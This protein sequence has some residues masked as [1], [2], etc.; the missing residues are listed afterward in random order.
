[1][2]NREF[3]TAESHDADSRGV[4]VCFNSNQRKRL[5]ELLN[6]VAALMLASCLMA[7]TAWSIDKFFPTFGNNGIDV[8]HYDLDLDVSIV[9]HHLE[10]AAN[11]DV[12]A[13]TELDSFSLD[14]TGLTVSKVTVRGMPADFVQED[15]KLKIRPWMPIAEG[16]VFE[17]EILYSGTPE[18]IQDPTF[19]NDPNMLLGWFKYED[20]IYAVSE[21]VGAS[22]FYPAN[23]EP[24]DKATFRIAVTV[25]SLATAVSNGVLKST[26]QVGEKRRF[27]WEMRQPMTSWLVTVHVNRFDVR[28]DRTPKGTPLRFYTTKETPA[29]DLEGYA[30]TGEMLVYFETLIGRY[31]FDGYGSVVVDDPAL[32]YAL[33]TQAMSTF[34]SYKADEGRVAHELAHQWF[35]NSVSVAKW[36]DLWLAEGPATYFEVLWVHR[37]DPAAFA[38]AMND[39][40][41]YVVQEKLGPAVVEAPELI[42]SDRTYLRGCIA[43]YALQLTV[44]DKTFFKILRRFVS[45]YRGGN[46]TSKNFINTA[47]AVSRH[48]SV[49]DLLE[50]WLYEETVPPLPGRAE[51]HSAKRG[52]VAAPDVVGLR[53]GRGAHRGPRAS[54]DE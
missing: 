37:N 30:L 9:P 42:F 16:D 38:L 50:A 4:G 35:G 5:M 18:P 2:D 53:C 41:D 32:Y 8:L 44:G 27:V 6:K 21:P 54:C 45:K 12:L 14:L 26:T 1:M 22:T 39:M 48:A 46:A 40:Y 23:D 17:V 34:P 47:V 52:P 24:T 28:L 25:P 20:A 15:D 3:R 11:L 13:L 36:E 29:E 10:A 51:S 49:G 31:P 7:S 33:E 19:P 43:L